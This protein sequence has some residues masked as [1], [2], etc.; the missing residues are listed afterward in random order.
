MMMMMMT[1]GDVITLQAFD[2]GAST[3]NSSSCS[4]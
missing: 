2:A 3:S 1:L 4:S